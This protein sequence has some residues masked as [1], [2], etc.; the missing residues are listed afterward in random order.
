M[1][2]KK[3][4]AP[5]LGL[6]ESLSAAGI[7]T[8]NS[9]GIIKSSS[10]KEDNQKAKKNTNERA[11][12]VESRKDTKEYIKIISTERCTPWQFADRQP[13]EMGNVKELA[14]SIQKTGQ[15]EPILVRPNTRNNDKFEFEII[16]GHRRWM[17]CSLIG[18]P[19]KAIVKNISDQDAA[20][21]QK[22]ENEN[23]KGISDFSKAMHYKKL[24][25]EKIFKDMSEIS[26]KLGIPKGSFSDLMAYTRIDKSIISAMPEPHQLSRKSAVRLA[27]LSKNLNKPTLNVIIKLA[28]DIASG[29]ISSLKILPTIENMLAD[30]R[31]DENLKQ[32]EKPN[33][34]KFYSIKKVSDKSITIRITGSV[35]KKLSVEEV[36]KG[37]D[38][39]LEVV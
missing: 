30:A 34:N 5:V 24:I 14:S 7:S 25:D 3:T 21:A 26:T 31:S 32:S 27:G 12:L 23:R 33:K 8:I 38:K 37:I 29:K 17:A 4:E 35:V 16:F 6:I 2:R 19:V 22:E 13:S 36:E 10:L 39:L 20:C 15:Q 28:P 11:R 1:K 18:V 9:T